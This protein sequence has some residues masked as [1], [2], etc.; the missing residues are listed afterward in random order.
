[1]PSEQLW[2]LDLENLYITRRPHYFLDPDGL[3]LV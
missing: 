3:R 2:C 1:M